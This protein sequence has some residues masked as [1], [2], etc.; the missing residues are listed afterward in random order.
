MNITGKEPT[1]EAQVRQSLSSKLFGLC[2][3]KDNYSGK[4]A[5]SQYMG[6]SITELMKDEKR[7]QKDIEAAERALE[8]FEHETFKAIL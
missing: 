1:T 3:K 4:Y 2:A 6:K 7:T 5:A 8:E